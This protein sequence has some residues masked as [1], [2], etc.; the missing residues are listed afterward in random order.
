VGC[1]NSIEHTGRVVFKG[2]KPERIE[3]IRDADASIIRPNRHDDS[4][5]SFK[6]F[7]PL[8]TLCVIIIVVFFF[9]FR[10]ISSDRRRTE[11]QSRRQSA[12]QSI[13]LSLIFV[14]SVPKGSLEINK[15][16][17]RRRRRRVT[18]KGIGPRLSKCSSPSTKSGIK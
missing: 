1:F 3:K 13:T 9:S 5:F 4:R 11:C 7:S 8:K 2:D 14:L 12:S 6:S 15:R 18:K 10:V 16:R 17:R